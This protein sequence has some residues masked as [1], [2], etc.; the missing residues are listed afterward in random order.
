VPDWDENSPRLRENLAR[1]RASIEQAARDRKLPTLDLARSWQQTIMEDLTVPD[2]LYVGR[3]R[4]EPGLE[5]CR[6]RIGAAWGTPPSEVAA[7]LVAFERKLQRTLAVLDEQYFDAELDADGLGAVIDVAAWAHAEWVRIHP[8]AN[9][10]G[11]TA[12]IWANF[13]LVRYGLPPAIRLRPRP[14]GG[15]EAAGARAMSGE[16]KPTAIVFRKLVREALTSPS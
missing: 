11:R 2:P 9:G 6:V 7:A 4:G 5:H 1:I 14:D 3:F 8:F 12:R 16:W 10:N 15:Y 13:V